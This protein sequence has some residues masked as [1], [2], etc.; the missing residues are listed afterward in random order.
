V[1][2]LKDQAQRDEAIQR[3]KRSRLPLSL[4]FRFRKNYC[5][6]QNSSELKDSAGGNM[7]LSVL[8]S[9]VSVLA[10]LYFL[11]IFFL[12]GQKS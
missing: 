3:A 6:V 9:L 12:R 2:G 10:R 7:R 4:A 5:Q 11:A 1:A 8:V